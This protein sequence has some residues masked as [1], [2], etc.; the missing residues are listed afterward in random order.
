MK[1]E[2]IPKF[3][4]PPHYSI[5]VNWKYL[6][7]QLEDWDDRKCQ[8][9]LGL[10]LDPDFQRGHVWTEDKQIAYVEFCLKGGQSSRT[11]LFNHPNWLGSY[12]G[13]MTLIDG[14]QRLEAVLRF[15]HNRLPVFNGNHLL[16]FDDPKKLLRSLDTH[17]IMSVNNLKTRK[18]VLQWYLQLNDGGVVHTTEEL[19]KVREMLKKEIES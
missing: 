3:F 17:F 19:D 10:N 14:K 7:Q 1:T 15:L 11:L 4:R 9:S 8:G 5:N 18:E 2:N 12:A 16:D 13:E 6:E